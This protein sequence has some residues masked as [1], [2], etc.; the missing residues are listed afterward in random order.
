[1]HTVINLALAL[2]GWAVLVRCGCAA[3][4]DWQRRNRDSRAGADRFAASAG[5]WGYVGER[6]GAG[7]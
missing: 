6:R 3:L 4:A 2:V 1:M 7:R 5:R